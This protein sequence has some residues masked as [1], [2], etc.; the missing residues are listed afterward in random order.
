MPPMVI[1]EELNTKFPKSKT[2]GKQRGMCTEKGWGQRIDKEPRDKA[3]SFSYRDW[4]FEAKTI[5]GDHRF[6]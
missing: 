6:K 3:D 2:K 4:S 1:S 5:S